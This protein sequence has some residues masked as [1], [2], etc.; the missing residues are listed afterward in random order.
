MNPLVSDP[1][2]PSFLITPNAAQEFI[3]LQSAEITRLR[4]D[5]EQLKA[6]S[7]NCIHEPKHRRNRSSQAT[8]DNSAVIEIKQHIS[9]TLQ[10]LVSG[11]KNELIDCVADRRDTVHCEPQDDSPVN[12]IREEITQCKNEIKGLK[13]QLEATIDPWRICI[14]TACKTLQL[15]R[16]IIANMNS[17]RQFSISA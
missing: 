17:V 5:V 10:E 16:E 15:Q 9:S 3:S 4:T 13:D 14:E 1:I 6:Q 12:E 11:L 8:L 2:S 7:A